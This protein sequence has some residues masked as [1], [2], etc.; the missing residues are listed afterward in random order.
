M[1]VEIQK[2]YKKIKGGAGRGGGKKKKKEQK[3]SKEQDVWEKKK[4]MTSEK[5]RKKVLE[6]LFKTLKIFIYYIVL[7][8]TNH[9]HILCSCGAGEGGMEGERG[10]GGQGIKDRISNKKFQ[11]WECSFLTS[12]KSTSICPNAEEN[13]WLQHRHATTTITSHTHTTPLSTPQHPVVFFPHL[14]PGPACSPPTHPPPSLPKYT[15]TPLLPTPSRVWLV[16]NRSLAALEATSRASWATVKPLPHAV[17]RSVRDNRFLSGRGEVREPA[18]HQSDQ[19][20]MMMIHVALFIQRS[21]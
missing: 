2:Q 3:T 11:T 14:V 19:R 18:P 4:H 1:T 5:K 20:V 8:F 21:H 15:S 17:C 9:R 10:G 13:P 6:L 7:Q 12:N 16:A